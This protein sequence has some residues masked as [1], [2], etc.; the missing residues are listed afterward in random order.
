MTK[1]I[2]YT[3]PDGSL[4]V[5]EPAPGCRRVRKI[6]GENGEHRFAGQGVPAERLAKARHN[7]LEME[8]EAEWLARVAA[9]CVPPGAIRPRIV[10]L[11]DLPQDRENRA[12][13][14]D[15]GTRVYVDPSR[16]KPAPIM[17]AAPAGAT[18]VQDPRVAALR[19]QLAAH[20]GAGFRA[21]AANL[22]A[23]LQE[24]KAEALREAAIERRLGLEALVVSS[25]I[26]EKRPVEPGS[27]PAI[28]ARL[29]REGRPIT[30]ETIIAAADEQGRREIEQARGVVR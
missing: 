11:A 13:W 22:D 27:Y 17:E 16:I 14:V 10:D 2:I 6:K 9:K 1:R 20:I 19:P 28:E 23:R 30:S 8:G 29:A 7:V 15:D 18:V 3:L 26:A 5:V 24:T 25:A 4:A 21:M 12:A